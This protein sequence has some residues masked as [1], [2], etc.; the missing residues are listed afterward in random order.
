[1]AEPVALVVV[2]MPKGFDDP[3]FWGRRKN[4]ACERNVAALIAAWRER[5]Q[6]VVF[7]RHDSK[8]PGSRLPAGQPG[9]AVKEMVSGE[10]DLLVTNGIQ[11]NTCCET[12]APV[13]ANLRLALNATHTFDLADRD[14]GTIPADQLARVTAA[15]LDLSTADAIAELDPR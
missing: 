11:A 14:G 9:N 1:V 2:D 6:L 3:G 15:N 4:P 12:T 13:G 5:G 7:V 8:E 10:S